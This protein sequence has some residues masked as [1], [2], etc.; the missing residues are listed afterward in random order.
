MEISSYNAMLPGNIRRIINE[1][2]LKQGAIAEKVGYSNQQFS[3]ILNGRRLIKPYDIVM[4]A[5]ALGVAVGDLFED[6]EAD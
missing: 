5:G 2:G 1:K 3:D 6:K 4:I